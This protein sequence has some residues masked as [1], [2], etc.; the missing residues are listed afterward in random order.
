MENIVQPVSAAPSQARAPNAAAS[1]GKEGAG[2]LFGLLLSAQTADGNTPNGIEKKAAENCTD[3][4]AS[5]LISAMLQGSIFIQNNSQEGT[6]ENN[7]QQVSTGLS[8][9][10]QSG[11]SSISAL[12]ALLNQKGSTG[13]G[14]LSGAEA[15][16]LSQLKALLG[17]AGDSGE[18]PAQLTGQSGETAESVLSSL[19]GDGVQGGEAAGGSQAGAQALDEIRRLFADLVATERNSGQGPAAKSLPNDP[20][21]IRQ[22]ADETQQPSPA[23]GALFQAPAPAQ[24]PGGKASS[25]G[26][27]AMLSG[28]A[29]DKAVIAAKHADA[30]EKTGVTAFGAAMKAA[31]SQTDIL[32]AQDTKKSGDAAVE[33]R[34]AFD[35]IVDRIT[36]MKNTSQKEMEISLKP[37]FLGK[38]V[39]HLTMDGGSLVAKISASNPKVQDAMMSQASALQSS[40]E[41]QGLKDVRVVVTS[42]SVAD[43]SLQQQADRQSRGDGSRNRRNAVVVNAAD[44]TEASSP[45][46]AYER[47]YSTGSINYLA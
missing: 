45:L 15:Q 24:Q 38:V 31:H 21:Q 19:S 37:D 22:E 39:I 36:S 32:A 27:D 17:Q 9:S 2:G 4:M 28:K 41:A 13:S 23:Q 26:A 33:A 14:P 46:S 25:G 40:L 44:S 42:S 47:A 35:S 10:A 34:Q 18:L 29:G 20:A 43:A 5:L 3:P 6:S 11:A 12:M 30:N 7:S 1:G 8:A 16:L